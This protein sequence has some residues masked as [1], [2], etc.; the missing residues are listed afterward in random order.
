MSTICPCWT[1]VTHTLFTFQ[2]SR[3]E[4]D[5]QTYV[6]IPYCI[7]YQPILPDLQKNFTQKILL[8]QVN[9]HLYGEKLMGLS[10]WI[11]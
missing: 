6:P 5:T 10:D 9:I 7:V 2:G 4:S 8:C 11:Q 3:T 1:C